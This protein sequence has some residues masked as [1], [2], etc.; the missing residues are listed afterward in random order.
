[1][2]RKVVLFSFIIIGAMVLIFCGAKKQDLSDAIKFKEEY[3]GFNGKNNDYFEYRSLSI[4]KKNP[5][6]YTTAEDIVKKI[7][8]KETFIV[9][10]GDPECPWCRSVI[11]EAVRSANNNN[12]KK[13]YY[14]R[15]WDGFHNEILRDVYELEDGEPV[16]KSKGTDAYYKLLTYFDSLLEEY[17]LTDNNNSINV[18]EK[19]IFAP[20]FVLVKKGEAKKIIQGISEKQESYNSDLNEKVINDE[21][22]IFDAFYKEY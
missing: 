15:M 6:I 5:F 7:E 14:V 12:I 21:K 9:Y 17:T 16:L 8:N 1:M 22:N 13:I 2:K 19:R 3:E 20:N 4:D 18:N 11:E 10:F